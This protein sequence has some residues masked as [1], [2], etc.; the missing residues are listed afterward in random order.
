MR[1]L[2]L[3]EIEKTVSRGAGACPLAA[4]VNKRVAL[5][6]KTVALVVSGA[7]STSTRLSA[8]SSAGS[9]KAARLVQLCRDAP[10]PR[11]GALAQLTGLS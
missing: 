3:L 2:L 1:S 6:G 5:P 8:S 4:L 10:R 9:S 7:T 11:P